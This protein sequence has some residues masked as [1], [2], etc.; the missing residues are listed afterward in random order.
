ME[1]RSLALECLGIISL[2]DESYAKM[3][4]CLI[5]QALEVDLKAVKVDIFLNIIKFILFF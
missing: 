4:I 1:I 5:E 2:C 3:H